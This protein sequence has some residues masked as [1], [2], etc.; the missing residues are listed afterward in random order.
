VR[1]WIITQYFHPENFGINQI[2]TNLVDRGHSVTV[3]SAMPNYPS[4]EFSPGYGGWRTRRES[5]DGV[6]VIR[7][8][9]LPRGNASLL[10]LALNYASYAIVSSITAPFLL[11]GRADIIFVYQPSPLTVA[12]PAIV[13][14]WIKRIPVVLWVQDLWPESLT[15]GN[16]LPWPFTLALIRKAAGFVYR[17]CSLILVQSPAYIASVRVL[18]PNVAIHYLPNSADSQYY[19]LDPPAAEPPHG[20]SQGFTVLFAGNIGIAQDFDAILSAAER[21][22]RVPDIQWVIVGEGRRRDWLKSEIIVRKLG[23]TV[24]LVDQQRPEAMPPYF[25]FANALLVTLSQSKVAALTIPAKLQAYLACGRPI[26][27]AVD[28]EAA[29]IVK[30]SGAGLICE[31]G[32]PAA[33]AEA[34]LELYKMSATERDRMGKAGRKYFEQ[35]FDH[36]VLMDELEGWLMELKN[37]HRGCSHNLNARDTT[38]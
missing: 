30:A 11:R 33:L 21:V 13:L 34:V 12:I 3:L 2:A 31:P 37:G 14:R 29:R 18:A 7:V 26:I 27:A 35:E 9:V 32:R 24:H 22:R 17:C 16:V 8:P 10:R 4:G 25:A 28:G 19:P 15:V 38:L 36:K 5:Y 23:D 1:I 20:L 6:S